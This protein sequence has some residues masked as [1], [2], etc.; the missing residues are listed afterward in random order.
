MDIIDYYTIKNIDM[1]DIY[2]TYQYETNEM[3]YVKFCYYID[4]ALRY[5][6]VNDILN[7]LLYQTIEEFNIVKNIH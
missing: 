6:K 4:I 1:L 2:I 5:D 3:Y 7:Q